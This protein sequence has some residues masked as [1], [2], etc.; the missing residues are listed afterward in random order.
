MFTKIDKKILIALII[1]IIVILLLG[2]VAYEYVLAPEFN[3]KNSAN[4]VK[5]EQKTEN[6]SGNDNTANISTQ[7]QLQAG[8][9]Q[10]Q[11]T[12]GN[13]NG[14]FSVCSDKCGDGICQKTDP[15]CTKDNSMNCIC[16]ETPQECPQ[17]CK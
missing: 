9:V 3:T 13:S 17:D 12:D 4:G 1:T 14:N 6:P 2:F 8:G 16:P 5:T 7:V 10:V 15:N 11:A